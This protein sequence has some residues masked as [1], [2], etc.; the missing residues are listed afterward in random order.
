M[1]TNGRPSMAK[2]QKEVAR[3]EKQREKAARRAQRAIARNNPA[4][5]P[6]VDEN[7]LPIE[8]PAESPET[9]AAAAPLPA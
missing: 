2:R 1:S 8:A 7:G 9:V 5:E 4:P 3:Q 6:A